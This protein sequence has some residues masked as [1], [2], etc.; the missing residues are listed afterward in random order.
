MKSVQ[1]ICSIEIP[2]SKFGAIVYMSE[3]LIKLSRALD[4]DEVLEKDIISF[5][6]DDKSNKAIA[7]V[8]K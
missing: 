5:Y 2:V 6:I 3:S 8:K 4:K 1:G 7:I